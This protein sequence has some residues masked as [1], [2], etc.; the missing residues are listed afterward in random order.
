[1]PLLRFDMA[2]PA[3]GIF[4]PQIQ[5]RA[6]ILSGVLLAA[7]VLIETLAHQPWGSWLAYASLG[8]GL[9]YGGKA[10]WEAL[11]VIEV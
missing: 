7:A 5:L 10:A 2:E 8:I 6:A 4:T 11:R 1:M 3:R 9:I